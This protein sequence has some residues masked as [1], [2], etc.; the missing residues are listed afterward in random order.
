MWA[1]MKEKPSH[2]AEGRHCHDK[3]FL[4]TVK[5]A[6]CGKLLG[7]GVGMRW[8]L[9]TMRWWYPI[10]GD[11]QGWRGSDGAVGV[12]AGREDGAGGL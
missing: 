8:P 4:T 10:P 6:P 5:A 9:M 3:A 12:P 2:L 1:G 7:N 11:I